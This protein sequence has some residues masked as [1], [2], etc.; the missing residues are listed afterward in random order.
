MEGGAEDQIPDLFLVDAGA[1]HGVGDDMR[2]QPEAVGVVESAPER[3]GERGAG[4]GNDDSPAMS[5]GS[6]E[7]YSEAKVWPALASRSSR[8]EGFQCGSP[9]F[10]CSATSV[11][12][13]LPAPT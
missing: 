3:P 2:A 12:W 9:V 10:S 4:G 1:C 6:G 11:S 13:I 8:A 7:D 5:C